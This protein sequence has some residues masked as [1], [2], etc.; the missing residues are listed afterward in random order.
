MRKVYIL[1]LVA[2]AAAI[3]GLAFAD[4]MTFTT[5][6]PAP[7]GVYREF[8]TSGN[9]Y[10]A[11]DE[12]NVGIGTTH[13]QAK[14]HM[15]G[16]DLRMQGPDNPS[17]G[18]SPSYISFWNANGQ[19]RYGYFGHGSADNA[20]VYL[21]VENGARLV[22]NNLGVQSNPV[23]LNIGSDGIVGTPVSSRRYKENIQPLQE[24]F[25]KILKLE[26]KSFTFKDSGAKSIGYIAEDVDE[27]GLK[28]L[29]VYKDGQP[30]TV[31][32]NL[33]PVYM[34]EIIKKQQNDIDT[35][36]REIRALKEVSPKT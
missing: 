28:D 14:L 29:V 23:S 8:R 13:P 15:V 3:I 19:F 20:N 34:L 16:T 33:I 18:W 2:L 17:G 5:Y 31:L 10:L 7:Y 24:D 1:G 32:Y 21:S 22:F 30:E 12:G 25:R 26:S 35:L 9:T 27:L 6:Y 11:T 36:K 4:Q